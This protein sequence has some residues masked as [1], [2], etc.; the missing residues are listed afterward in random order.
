MLTEAGL[1][2]QSQVGNAPA[3]NAPA[4]KTAADAVVTQTAAA[5]GGKAGGAPAK[6]G[7]APAPSVGG[8]ASVKENLTTEEQR[9][10]EKA[11][12]A[13][14][15]KEEAQ[16]EQSA[17]HTMKRGASNSQKEDAVLNAYAQGVAAGKQAAAGKAGGKKPQAGPVDEGANALLGADGS[18]AGMGK[19][20]STAPPPPPV[21]KEK[22]GGKEE[23]AG[24]KAGKQ[25][26]GKEASAGGGHVAGGH[27]VG[28]AGG[29]HAG[30]G[31]G[32]EAPPQAAGTAAGGEATNFYGSAAVIVPPEEKS[33][34]EEE[35]VVIP[36]K[37]G[38]DWDDQSDDQEF[39]QPKSE[40]GVPPSPKNAHKNAEQAK[41]KKHNDNSQ[42]GEKTAAKVTSPTTGDDHDAGAGGAKTA[43]TKAKKKGIDWDDQDYDN[44]FQQAP[45]ENRTPSA[46][47]KPEK[48]PEK[49]LEKEIED[50][51]KHRLDKEKQQAESTSE[52]KSKSEEE[53]QTSPSNKPHDHDHGGEKVA[54]KEKSWS[55]K[56]N[57]T[58]ESDTA[59]V[60][61]YAAAARQHMKQEAPSAKPSLADVTAKWSE[62]MTAMLAYTNIVKHPD[63][64]VKKGE[65]PALAKDRAYQKARDLS[66]QY[67]KAKEEAGL[68]NEA[69]FPIA[70]MMEVW[71]IPETQLEATISQMPAVV[72]N[73]KV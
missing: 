49:Q 65:D 17:L 71:N 51:E 53:A 63:A 14:A 52:K 16:E 67:Q 7:G 26:G 66:Y 69:M 13:V 47:N 45:R 37:K 34:K 5:L 35:N 6:A 68:Q 70:P 64:H 1:A 42:K 61:G 3:G 40:Q 30:A 60:L 2:A 50:N 27:T 41:S 73:I 19:D 20:R 18:G 36:K 56:H 15:A 23:Q 10:K 11:A 8:K 9:S 48:L 58:G 43:V 12:D 33:S 29:A 54:K 62:A 24:G 44:E 72:G 31:R 4:G 55:L 57:A 32:T 22:A 28:A 25:A 59:T 39:A 46:K 38:I 21:A